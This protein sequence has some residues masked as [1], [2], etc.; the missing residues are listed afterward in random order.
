MTKFWKRKDFKY[1]KIPKISPG[2]YIFQRPFLG[3]LILEWLIF[4]G[5]Y[6]WREICVSKQIGLAL[7]LE[8]NLIFS[9]YFILYLRAIF[10]VKAPGGLIL[11][12]G[13]FALPVWRTYI[14]RGLFSEFYGIQ[15]VKFQ[16]FYLLFKWF[17]NSTVAVVDHWAL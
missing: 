6:L 13:F 7:Q 14:Q 10:Q 9:L 12:E 4:V 15:L 2:D 11:T 17:P 16:L 8:V 1:R 3:V 5:A